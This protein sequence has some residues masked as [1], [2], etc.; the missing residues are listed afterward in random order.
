MRYIHHHYA[1]TSVTVRVPPG[2]EVVKEP[3]TLTG[4]GAPDLH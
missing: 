1:F 4:D 2:V 3:R